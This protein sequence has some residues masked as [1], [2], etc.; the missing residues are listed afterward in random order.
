M[1]VNA[2][3]GMCV[4]VRVL[5]QL[6]YYYVSTILYFYR[7]SVSLNYS[8]WIDRAAY[9][10]VRNPDL[11]AGNNNYYPASSAF[12]HR[13]NNSNRFSDCSRVLYFNLFVSRVAGEAAPH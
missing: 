4:C 6:Y 9:L 11:P 8:T 13:L 10:Y 2:F 3:V 1:A 7:L 5:C 12:S